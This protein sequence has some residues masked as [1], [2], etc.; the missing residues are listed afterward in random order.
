MISYLQNQ[1]QIKIFKWTII[2]IMQFHIIL[3]TKLFIDYRICEI[4]YWN[5]SYCFENKKKLHECN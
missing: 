1:N 4:A 3:F 2:L 5:E